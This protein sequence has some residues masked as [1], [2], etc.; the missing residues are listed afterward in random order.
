MDVTISILIWTAG[1]N[2]VFFKDCIE[3]ILRQEYRN[4]ELVIVDETDDPKIYKYL[5]EKF[6]HDGRLVIHRLKSRKNAAH[7]LNIALHKR[8]GEYV[9]FMG[10]HDRLS[11]DALSSFVK[12]INKSPVPDFIYTDRD[13][14]ASYRFS[15]S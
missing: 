4:F 5:H 6:A 7:A 11:D 1:T 2:Q 13:E 10:Q 15:R 12:E 14:S 3:S 9:L 8:K